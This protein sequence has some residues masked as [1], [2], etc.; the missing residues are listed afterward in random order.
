MLRDSPRSF[1]NKLAFKGHR[2][3]FWWW[4]ALC[5]PTADSCHQTRKKKHIFHI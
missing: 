1:K 2:G 3:L 4:M 5:E